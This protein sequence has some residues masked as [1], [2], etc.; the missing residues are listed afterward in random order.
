MTTMTPIKARYPISQAQYDAFWADGFLVVPQLIESSLVPMLHDEYDRAIAGEFGDLKWSNSAK[1]G[2][3]VQKPVHPSAIPGWDKHPYRLNGQSV[4]EQLMGV[5]LVFRYG[6][7]IRKPAHY[8]ARVQ[9]HQDG[10]YWQDDKNS[11]NAHKGCTCWVALSEAFP[12]N[13]SVM[14]IT[15]SHRL[16]LLEHTDQSAIFEFDNAREAQ[17]F[18][19]SKAV[20][21]TMYPGD[22]V[23][24]HPLTVHG[25]GGNET[26]VVREGLTSHFFVANEA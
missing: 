5:D 13:G 21:V 9:W 19:P 17:G 10:W 25:S 15:G 14:Y 23:F 20:A 16:G 26:D 2:Q 18:D 11:I 6:Q 3:Q 7:M 22:A 8:P 12:A 24:H 1:M 4:C